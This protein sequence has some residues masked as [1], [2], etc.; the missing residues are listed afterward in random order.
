MSRDRE[1]PEPR[2]GGVLDMKVT[3]L[4]DRILVKMVETETQD[5]GRDPHPADRAGED[6]GRS[7]PGGWRRRGD[8]GEGEGSGHL[9]QV[10][11]D[12]D[13]G[14]RR[15]AAHPEGPD[16]LA[17]RSLA[18]FPPHEGRRFRPS[19]FFSPP[20]AKNSATARSTSAASA[21]GRPAGRQA[22][23]EHRAIG[24]GNDPRVQ[25]KDHPRS[26]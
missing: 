16:I 19:P 24:L 21:H 11:R 25:D 1:I 14:R 18:R 15:G 20:P 13:Q 17:S 10:R 3:P 8:Q 23:Q 9:R 22:L 26:S 5:G 6:P 12:H 2:K 7:R 4:G